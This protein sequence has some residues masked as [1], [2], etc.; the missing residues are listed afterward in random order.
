MRYFNFQFYT[1]LFTL[2]M[3]T[4]ESM[5]SKRPFLVIFV[6]LFT[7][8]R[9]FFFHTCYNPKFFNLF[10]HSEVLVWVIGKCGKICCSII[11]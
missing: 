4:A 1:A 5:L 9:L 11:L 6:A 2:L 8:L 3:M 7:L 10:S